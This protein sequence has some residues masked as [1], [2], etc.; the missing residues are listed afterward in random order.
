MQKKLFTSMMLLVCSALTIFA[1]VVVFICYHTYRG[2]AFS[3]L[4][5]TANIIAMTDADP[6]VIGDK[7]DK[8]VEEYHIRVTFIDSDGKVV[9]DSDEDIADMDNH[10]D[11]QE[12]KQALKEG[13]GE[14]ERL[15][16]TLDKTYCYYAIAYHGG[17]LRLARTRSS[18]IT[19]VGSVFALLICAVGILLVIATGRERNGRRGCGKAG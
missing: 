9:Y 16:E 11:R 3:E 13:E 1:G 10:A 15:S 8:T 14:D 6:A 5:N 4:R 17:V 12:V 7:I 18:M 19:I 2:A